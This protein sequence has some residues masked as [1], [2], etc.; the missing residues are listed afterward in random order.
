MESLFL[1]LP[2]CKSSQIMPVI[3]ICS[4]KKQVIQQTNQTIIKNTRQ[5]L[6]KDFGPSG[7]RAQS[8]PQFT[9][10]SQSVVNGSHQTGWQQVS[11]L[12]LAPAWRAVGAM[13]TV[14]PTRLG[15]TTHTH[16]RVRRARGVH[17][18]KQRERRR[19]MQS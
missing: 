19:R 12:P 15:Y 13:V 8:H 11:P 14:S 5:N 17:H 16:T 9:S 7:I 18:H 3:E 10:D 2:S 1:S 6:L 4:C